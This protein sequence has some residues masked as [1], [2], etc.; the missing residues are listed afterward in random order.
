MVP[1]VVY[2]IGAVNGTT[3]SI[4]KE[5]NITRYRKLASY[6]KYI[7]RALMPTKVTLAGIYTPF[8]ILHRKC[9]KPLQY[10]LLCAA[11]DETS[12]DIMVRF[13]C[14]NFLRK[15]RL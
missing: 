7:N 11:K 3:T 8:H 4:A 9:V 5:V 2:M 6:K 13:F 14:C 10:L 15:S 1:T 12:V